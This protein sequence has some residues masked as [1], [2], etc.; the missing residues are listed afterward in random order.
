[1]PQIRVYTGKGGGTHIRTITGNAS[2]SPS[3]TTS[4]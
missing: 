4:K 1:M 3:T 2:G